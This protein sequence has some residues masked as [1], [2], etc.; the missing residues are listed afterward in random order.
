MFNTTLLHQIILDT[1]HATSLGITFPWVANKGHFVNIQSRY[2]LITC[3]IKNNVSLI[4]ELNPFIWCI[5]NM[6]FLYSFFPM[7][8]CLSSSFLSSGRI[9]DTD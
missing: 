5:S 4:S 7:F 2:N 1:V 8:S 9:E 3:S 6:N